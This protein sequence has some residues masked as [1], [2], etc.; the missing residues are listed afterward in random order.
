ML[1]ISKFLTLR[2]LPIKWFLASDLRTSIYTPKLIG[3]PCILSIKNGN[4]K[5]KNGTI[6]LRTGADIFINDNICSANDDEF[7]YLNISHSI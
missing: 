4:N 7:K 5:N 1:L 3:I 6:I 2:I